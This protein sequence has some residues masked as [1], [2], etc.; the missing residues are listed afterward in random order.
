MGGALI[1]F[2]VLLAFSTNH[3]VPEVLFT[4]PL[5]AVLGTAFSGFS[6]FVLSQSLFSLP[7]PGLDALLSVYWAIMDA[8]RGVAEEG[9]DS[10]LTP[11]SNES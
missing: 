9:A 2:S 8:W 10:F 1:P 4:L 6:A 5:L 7:P 3:C 11:E